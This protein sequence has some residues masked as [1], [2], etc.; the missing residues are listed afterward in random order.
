MSDDEVGR[1]YDELL[2]TL[3]RSGDRRAGERL[4]VRWHP[5]LMRLARRLL[6]DEEQA[7]DAV[8]ETWAGIFR[9]IGRLSDPSKFRAWAFGILR[10]KCADRIAAESLNRTRLA[11]LDEDQSAVSGSALSRTAIDQAMD[12]L[13]PDHRLVA[14]LFFGEGLTLAEIAAAIGVPMGT[15]KSRLFHARQ[16]LKAD[17]KGD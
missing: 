2:V 10:R 15:A 12:R 11:P 4:C 3:V 5:R 7:R 6:R 8:Q 9:G 1:V 14:L 13:S 17:L 16:K